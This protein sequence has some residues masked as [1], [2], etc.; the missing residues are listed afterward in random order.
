MAN[1]T[2]KFYK[3]EITDALAAETLKLA[4]FTSAYT[5]NANTDELYSSLTGEVSASGTGY[6][7][8]GIAVSS[9]LTSGYVDT[10]NARLDADDLSLASASFTTRYGVLYNTSN[11][12]IRAIFDW[13][14]DKVVTTGTIAILWHA[15]GILK[16]K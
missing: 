6:T 11:S 14:G 1:V 5:P 4:L 15:D 16:V 7:T 8:G 2:P 12:K 13:G 9:G 3:K 10:T